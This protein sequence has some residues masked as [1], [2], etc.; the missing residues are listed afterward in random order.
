[1]ARLIGW[2]RRPESRKLALSLVDRYQE[3]TDPKRYHDAAWPVIRHPYANPFQYRFALMQA[4][5]AC[6]LAPE[7]TK[8]LIA[9]G[10]AQ[11]RTGKYKEAGET[12]Q[13]AEPTNKDMPAHLAFLTMAHHHLG[14]K[15]EAKATLARLREVMKQERWA[16]DADAQG[17]LR[18]AEET[19]NQKPVSETTK[20][21]KKED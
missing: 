14:M 21:T 10:A 8:Y 12:L 17:F 11:Y 20:D 15:N 13:K 19:L 1:L 16:N 2:R 7:E 3:A 9:L 4:E 6:R 5:T 18:E